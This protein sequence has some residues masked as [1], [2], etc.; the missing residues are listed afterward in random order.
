LRKAYDNNIEAF[1][2]SPIFQDLLSKG[3]NRNAINVGEHV[4]NLQELLWLDDYR[5]GRKGSERTSSLPDS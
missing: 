2:N 1:K 4:F 3:K 5:H